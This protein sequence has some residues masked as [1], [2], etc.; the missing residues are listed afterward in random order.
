[1][2]H[3]N[4]AC[5]HFHIARIYYFRCS[6]TEVCV[7]DTHN[8]NV[9]MHTYSD[10]VCRVCMSQ[11]CLEL[12]L[13]GGGGRFVNFPVCILFSRNNHLPSSYSRAC[14]H[15]ELSLMRPSHV[16]VHVY[17]TLLI[18][19]TQLKGPGGGRYTSLHIA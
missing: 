11:G 3:I 17:A 14:K 8:A 1:M 10:V 18:A 5:I 19:P 4:V 13:G 9:H 6:C 2:K 15:A 12:T 7:Y 16:H